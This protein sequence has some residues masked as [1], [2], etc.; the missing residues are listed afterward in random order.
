MNRTTT[1]LFALTLALGTL[2]PTAA[3]ADTK[4]AYVDLQR[5]LEETEDGKKAKAK[6]K[7]DFDRKQDELNKKQEEL[8][9]MSDDFEKTKDVMKQEAQAKKQQELQNRLVELQQT[10]ARLQRDLASK[11]QDA[12]R[13]IFANLQLVV[14]Q[15][16]EREH[17]D[18]VLE[19][20]SSVVWAKPALEI[21]NE[22]IRTYNQQHGTGGTGK[23]K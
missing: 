18:V 17:F 16:A 23:T 15:I 14:G 11:E 20:N 13:G 21:T 3:L 1:N 5:A 4:V 8:K 6:L 7:A 19:K 22:V 12:T 9:K 10:Y 2:A